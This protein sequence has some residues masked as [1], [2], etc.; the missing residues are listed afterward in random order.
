MGVEHRKKQE[1]QLGHALVN[2]TCK[3]SLVAPSYLFKYE[4]RCDCEGIFI[5]VDNMHDQLTN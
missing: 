1:N 5:N 4:S 3:P 2:F